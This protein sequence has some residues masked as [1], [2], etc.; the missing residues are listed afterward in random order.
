MT[1]AYPSLL[2]ALVAD[3][4]TFASTFATPF[5]VHVGRATGAPPYAVL[6]GP[7]IESESTAAPD[8]ERATAP[9]GVL[10]TA[11]VFGSFGE[12]ITISA[13]VQDR[14]LSGAV[15]VPGRTVVAAELAQSV[16]IPSVP[17]V[18]GEPAVTGRQVGVRFTTHPA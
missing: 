16:P 8:D 10:M 2:S 9:S 6:G 17:G 1:S 18:S 7:D 13:A 15:A 12:A 4:R 3:L 5:A 11:R 14:W